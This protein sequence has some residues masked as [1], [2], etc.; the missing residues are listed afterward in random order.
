MVTEEIKYRI[1]P[2]GHDGP[3]PER[4]IVQPPCELITVFKEWCE[5]AK[6]GWREWE[7][8]HRL[9]E[10]AISLLMPINE[11]FSVDDVHA[12]V[13]ACDSP[14]FV[15]E[16]A[17]YFVSACY[18]LNDDEVID[19]NVATKNAFGHVG[20]HFGEGKVFVN[21][22]SI[23]NIAFSGADGALI[24]NYG[25]MRDVGT[26]YKGR[27][28]NYGSVLRKN[29]SGIDTVAVNMGVCESNLGQNGNGVVINFGDGGSNYRVDH[30]FSHPLYVG[31]GTT[32]NPIILHTKN[33]ICLSEEVAYTP[34]Q[35]ENKSV[36]SPVDCQKIPALKEY[37]S[38][39]K[40]RLEAG[41]HD[42]KKAIKVMKSLSRQQ[43][44]Q[45]V[46]RMVTEAGFAWKR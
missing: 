26:I 32:V 25:N 23:G 13:V 42:V 37:F 34:E 15:P 39:L 21:R 2:V 10:K 11:K 22:G 44:E 17:G 20:Y 7:Y 45:D 24:I 28:L 18:N 36:L 27:F 30:S 38:E 31:F 35:L 14:E 46:E 6:K 5:C 41:R 9:Y 12:L 43:L 1:K 8:E 33:V 19:F 4:K 29:D 40:Q 16:L 3:E